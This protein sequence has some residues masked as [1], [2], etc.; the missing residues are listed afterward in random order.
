LGFRVEDSVV[1][2]TG[3][4]CRVH[5]VGLGVQGFRGLGFRETLNSELRGSGKHRRRAERDHDPRPPRGPAPRIHYR[6]PL[7]GVWCLKF[8]VGDLVFRV[9][10]LGF[11]VWD[12]VSRF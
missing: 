10:G 4:G 6:V 7:C 9:Q 8:G 1:V 12:S 2:V 3:L 11:R 5:G